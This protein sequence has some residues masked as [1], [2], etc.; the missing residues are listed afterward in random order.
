MGV[1]AEDIRAQVGRL[2]HSK[3]FETSDVHRR[4]LQYLAEKSIS[5]DADRLKEYTIGLEAFGKPPLTI[6]STTPLSASRPAG[7]ARSWR[8]ITKPKPPAT[9]SA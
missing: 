3:T 2:I 4:L 6:P 9:P 1:E 8:R 5:G 7:C